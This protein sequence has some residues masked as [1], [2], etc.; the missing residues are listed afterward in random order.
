MT[1]LLSVHDIMLNNSVDDCC[2][3]CSCLTTLSTSELM[4]LRNE[5]L[6]KLCIILIL[7]DVLPCEVQLRTVDA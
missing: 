7:D 2:A 6:L 3:L 1:V 5:A 4:F